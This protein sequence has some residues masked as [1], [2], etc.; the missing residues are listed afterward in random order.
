MVPKY[1]RLDRIRCQKNAFY[2]DY[3]GFGSKPIE[4]F[5]PY[6]IFKEYITNH[7]KAKNMF[8]A[9]FNENIFKNNAFEI[10][11]KKG[12]WL[13]GSTYKALSLLFTHKNLEINRNTLL[14][15][16]ELVN[17]VILERI[18]YF[19]DV[20]LSIR[21]NGFDPSTQPIKA[22]KKKRFYYLIN[23]HHRVAMLS[24]L[25]YKNLYIYKLTLFQHIFF[26]ILH[27]K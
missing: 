8:I 24:V 10:P 23:G 7:E 5:P 12:G 27:L 2:S 16:K 17:E 1:I 9:F 22:E 11:K 4:F 13:K 6:K 26:F 19:F 20:F 18:D 15:Y 25:G 21:K 3:V 14:H